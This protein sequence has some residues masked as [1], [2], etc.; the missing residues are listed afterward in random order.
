MK[1]E[2]VSV[3]MDNI[4]VQMR[5]AQKAVW[6]KFYPNLMNPPSHLSKP[7]KDLRQDCRTHRC[8]HPHHR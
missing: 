8:G 3:Y 5:D 2:A 7:R 1:I 6:D 4:P